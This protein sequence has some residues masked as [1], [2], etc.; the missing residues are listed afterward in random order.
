MHAAACSGVLRF[1]AQ[2]TTSGSSIA[3]A[4]HNINHYHFNMSLA[5]PHL[6]GIQHPF[7]STE[8]VSA[9]KSGKGMYARRVRSL[10][11]RLKRGRSQAP[12]T[13][14]LACSSK[15]ACT[16]A[17]AHVSDCLFPAHS[18]GI[19]PFPDPS[20][21]QSTTWH[22]TA[23]CNQSC[24]RPSSVRCE[25]CSAYLLA[26]AMKAYHSRKWQ[27]SPCACRCSI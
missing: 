19:T 6:L 4:P 7:I 25:V 15:A 3:V 10:F 17:S 21:S 24:P 18:T 13:R 23:R 9:R 26:E 16:L 20:M 14:D 2:D 27:T 12:I 8:Y 5:L 22:I 1:T 11:P